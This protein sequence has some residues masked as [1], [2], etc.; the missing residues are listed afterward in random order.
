MLLRIGATVSILQI[1]L[2]AEGEEVGSISAAPP[3]SEGVRAT[4]RNR[5]RRSCSSA[6]ARTLCRCLVRALRTAEAS[7]RRRRRN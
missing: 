4:R 1:H 3:G 2:L 7:R 5:L 6:N